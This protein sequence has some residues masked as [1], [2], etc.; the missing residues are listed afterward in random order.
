MPH[1]E[2]L[3][4]DVRC[5]MY[6]SEPFNLRETRLSVIV[7][8]VRLLIT[9]RVHRLHTPGCKPTVRSAGCRSAAAA[10]V[11]AIN[12]RIHCS[13][14]SRSTVLRPPVYILGAWLDN[15]LPKI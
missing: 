12:H 15:A 8:S 1:I 3:S 10:A 2:V 4:T 6:V 9:V 7:N 5:Y 11:P 13:R 14:T